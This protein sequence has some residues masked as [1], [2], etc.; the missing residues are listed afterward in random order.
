[1]D[2]LPKGLDDESANA[3]VGTFG[4]YLSKIIRE[5]FMVYNENLYT[6]DSGQKWLNFSFLMIGLWENLNPQ[7]NNPGSTER[8]IKVNFD[9]DKCEM[10]EV[11]AEDAASF[12]GALVSA[13]KKF[14]GIDIAQNVTYH[15]IYR[16][17]QGAFNTYPGET[18]VLDA[19]T[20]ARLRGE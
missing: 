8:G 14:L 3:L 18:Y 20:Y 7:E 6:D 10:L 13:A 5:A 1:M 16:D 17:K 2:L 4:P 19:V 9:P 12:N 15:I 11:H